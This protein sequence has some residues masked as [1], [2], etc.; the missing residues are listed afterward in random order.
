MSSHFKVHELLSASE[1]EEL[2][3]FAREPGRTIDEVHEWMLARGFTLARTSAGTWLRKFRE[4]LI[5]QRFNSSG[6]LARAIKDAVAGGSFDDVAAAANMQLVNVVFEQ[7]ARLQSEGELDSE[8]VE[9]M[10]RSLKNLVGTKAQHAKLLAEKFDR[11]M[12]E[13]S[14]KGGGK[15]SGEDVAA[16]RKA[17]FGT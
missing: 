10:T 8:A 11:E 16:A 15:I 7:A 2:E 6:E 1:L 9:S 13:R 14:A 5:R 12:A 3:K 17:I 4:E